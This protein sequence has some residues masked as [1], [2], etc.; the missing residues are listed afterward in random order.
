MTKI[1]KISTISCSIK[2]KRCS[3]PWR[4]STDPAYFSCDF[5][6]LWAS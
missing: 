4:L 1:N 6:T 3:E 5:Y 2:D